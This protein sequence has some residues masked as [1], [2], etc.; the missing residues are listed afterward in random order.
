MLRLAPASGFACLH[1]FVF[2]CGAFALSSSLQLVLWPDLPLAFFSDL[3]ASFFNVI[4]DGF[5]P[6]IVALVCPR[7]ISRTDRWH[8][9]GDK[10]AWPSRLFRAV[11]ARLAAINAHATHTTDCASV[12][13]RI[14]SPITARYR[15]CNVYQLYI[16][17]T[18]CLPRTRTSRGSGGI[19]IKIDRESSEV[20]LIAAESLIR[21]AT[22][23]RHCFSVFL[24]FLTFTPLCSQPVVLAPR[25][26]LVVFLSNRE[27]SISRSISS[28]SGSRRSLKKKRE[29]AF[30]DIACRKRGRKARKAARVTPPFGKE[31]RHI[32]Y[33]YPPLSLLRSYFI[34]R[35]Q[36]SAGNYRNKIHYFNGRRCLSHRGTFPHHCRSIKV[37]LAY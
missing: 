8:F 11:R 2:C 24:F 13:A 4:L 1:S 10:S 37:L 23:I 16:A 19:E 31:G 14:G 28:L 9:S 20:P 32:P 22:V 29:G 35:F 34:Y 21:L 7:A 3:F 18:F 12:N 5:S 25:W 27:E 30:L 36:S 26:T 6:T 17:L 15:R 33:R